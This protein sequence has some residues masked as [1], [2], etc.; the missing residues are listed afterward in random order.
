[1]KKSYHVSECC[2]VENVGYLKISKYEYEYTEKL[3]LTTSSLPLVSNLK[4]TSYNRTQHYLRFNSNTFF[5]CLIMI[6]LL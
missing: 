4:R 2:D 6:E 3:F 5:S 1:M